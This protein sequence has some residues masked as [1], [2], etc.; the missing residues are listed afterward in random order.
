MVYNDKL[1]LYIWN[2]DDD[3]YREIVTSP[4]VLN[5]TFIGSSNT[6]AV[7][8]CVPFLHL[9]L[10]LEQPLVSTPQQY[11]PCYA[12]PSAEE[13]T[14]GRAFLQDA[15]IGANWGQ[16]TWWL[17]Q[18]PGPKIA[19]SPN[20]HTITE[21]STSIQAGTNNWEKSWSTYWTVLTAPPTTT[22]PSSTNETSGLPKDAQIRIGV[23]VGVGVGGTVVLS[24]LAFFLWHRSHKRGNSP[25]L[26]QVHG[27]QVTEK[28]ELPVTQP[29]DILPSSQ[30]YLWEM[31]ATQ[32]P[33]ELS[34]FQYLPQRVGSVD[35]NY[36]GL[37]HEVNNPSR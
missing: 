5:F 12:Y 6:D 18:A 3:K 13:F 20:I 31:D 35:C 21:T 26:N 36:G 30:S 28:P 29:L 24:I 25:V 15:F 22:S 33:Q 32:N 23:G 9:N 16:S 14:L 4:S 10:T 7:S 2:T 11:F 37:N 1:G 19:A 27:Y 8:I 34:D 17:A